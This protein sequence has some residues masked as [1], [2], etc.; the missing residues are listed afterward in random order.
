MLVPPSLP[1]AIGSPYVYRCPTFIQHD[2][3]MLSTGLLDGE[4]R[5]H[6]SPL[7]RCSYV[8]MASHP[9]KALLPRGFSPQKTMAS[10]TN[11]WFLAAI[12][13][14]VPAPICVSSRLL[15]YS[16]SESNSVVAYIIVYEIT[17][18]WGLYDEYYC[19]HFRTGGMVTTHR[20]VRGDMQLVPP[21]D[22]LCYT[23]LVP[24]QDVL[25]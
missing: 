17:I 4:D 19:S 15:P 9:R 23:L 12:F 3:W 8:V 5:C 24:P 22:T 1:S 10:W 11:C 2:R 14:T 18:W 25:C 7:V 21:E 13:P 20:I 16:Q 6:T